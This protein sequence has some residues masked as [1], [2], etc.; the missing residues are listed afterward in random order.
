[1]NNGTKAARTVS[2][3]LILA[4][5]LALPVRFANAATDVDLPLDA[6][7]NDTAGRSYDVVQRDSNGNGVANEIFYD[8]NKSRYNIDYTALLDMSRVWAAYQAIKDKYQPLSSNYGVNWNDLAL[9]GE[10]DIKFH[11]DTNYVDFDAATYANVPAIQA[12]Y[13]V[14][15][16]GRSGDFFNMMKVSK[17]DW[18]AAA[19]DLTIA[20]AFGTAAAKIPVPE[21]EANEANFMEA[22]RITLPEG[23]L[24][25]PQAK[26]AD[27]QIFATVGTISGNMDIYWRVPSDFNHTVNLMGVSVPVTAANLFPEYNLAKPITTATSIPVKIGGITVDI[28][29]GTQ[30]PGAGGFAELPLNFVPLSQPSVPIEMLKRAAIRDF[31]PVVISAPNTGYRAD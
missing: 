21:L 29:A 25:V 13:E 15:N 4:L 30:Y 11:F 26:F 3:I 9:L 2:A 6:V 31:S 1:M 23:A 22:I 10:F 14:S 27:G 7:A 8:A 17:V 5:I 20:L 28:P 19:G 18:D 16:T 12:A 24:S